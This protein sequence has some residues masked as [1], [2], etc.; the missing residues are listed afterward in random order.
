MPSGYI[1]DIRPGMDAGPVDRKTEALL[2]KHEHPNIDSAVRIDDDSEQDYKDE[3][4]R[5]RFSNE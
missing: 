5:V 2:S 4:V 3:F 1:G